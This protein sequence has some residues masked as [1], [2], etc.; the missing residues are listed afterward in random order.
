ML[1]KKLCKKTLFLFSDRVVRYF[2]ENCRF[3]IRGLIIK[4]SR[5]PICGLACI[6]NLRNELKNLRVCDLRTVKNSLPDYLC[7]FSMLDF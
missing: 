2:V 5:F 3:A 7:L 1:R 4:I 6:R